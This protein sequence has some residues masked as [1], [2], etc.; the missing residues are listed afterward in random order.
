MLR[1]A[2]RSIPTRRPSPSTRGQRKA[3]SLAWYAVLVQSVFVGLTE[4]PRRRR[5]GRIL[6]EILGGEQAERLVKVV[7]FCAY[8]VLAKLTVSC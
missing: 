3:E 7:P 8:E 2:S 1:A 5:P 4:A 6:F